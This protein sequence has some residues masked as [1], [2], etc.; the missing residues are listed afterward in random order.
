MPEMRTHGGREA[1][2]GAWRASWPEPYDTV[3]VPGDHWSMAETHARTTAGA[4]R[5]WLA[6]LGANPRAG[7]RDQTT[8][9]G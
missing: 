5:V 7:D 2:G 8:G 6:A 1:H 3:D 4:I 9:A